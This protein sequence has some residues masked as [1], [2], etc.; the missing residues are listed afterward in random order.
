MTGGFVVIE[1]EHWETEVSP[2]ILYFSATG[3]TRFVALQ[4][5]ERLGDEALDL[6]DRI[7]RDD[8]SPIHSDRPFV[9]CAPTYVCEMPRFFADY[10][11]KTPLTGSAA[12]YFIFTSGGYCGIS[13]TLARGIAGKKGLRY[14]GCAELTMPRTYTAN[15]HYPELETPEIERRI[16]ASAE[17]IG[18][19]AAAIDGGERLKS[20]HV[21]LFELLITLP[22]NPVWVRVKQGVADF[23]AT[24]SCVGCGKCARLCPLNVIRMEE[25]KPVWRGRTCA[26][27]MSCIQNC[28]AEAIEYGQITPVKARYR[29][30]RYRYA[31]KSPQPQADT[32]AR[33]TARAAGSDRQENSGCH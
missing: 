7:K 8:H 24:D 11:R 25:G 28:P 29:F 30:D 14:M 32:N 26:H 12:A 31:L 13:G 9:I 16:R 10:L 23:R 21:W 20:R 18:P 33:K 6:L 5:A 22:F 15:N 19:I 17:A 3:N 2:L 1:I 27:C 4:L